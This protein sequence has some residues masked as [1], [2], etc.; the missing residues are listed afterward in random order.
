MDENANKSDW[1]MFSRSRSNISMSCEKVVLSCIF[2][3]T[4][5][6]VLAPTR[7]GNRTC[8]E[9]IVPQARD[10]LISGVLYAYLGIIGLPHHVRH[11]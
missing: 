3:M 9:C 8:F 11:E 1:R 4:R 6:R 10:L 2:S 7:N 5:V